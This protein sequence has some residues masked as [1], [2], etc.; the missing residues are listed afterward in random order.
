M[1]SAFGQVTFRASKI[2]SR[3][4]DRLR[5]VSRRIADAETGAHRLLLAFTTTLRRSAE[6]GLGRPLRFTQ[7]KE[8]L[9]Q[10]R[11]FKPVFVQVPGAMG[12]KEGPATRL[13]LEVAHVSVIGSEKGGLWGDPKE[14]ER[15]ERLAAWSVQLQDRYVS[16]DSLAVLTESP[17]AP[18]RLHARESR[19]SWTAM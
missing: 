13:A 16:L 2:Q 3:G 12:T 15:D 10:V 7:C 14:L 9:A 8:A 6:S 18:S 17:E 11:D 19:R 5:K 1:D 4:R